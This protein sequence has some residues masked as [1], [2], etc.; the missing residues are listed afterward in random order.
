M[1]DTFNIVKVRS[2]DDIG[3]DTIIKKCIDKPNLINYYYP[4]V[5]MN[6]ESMDKEEISKIFNDTILSIKRDKNLD[7]TIK[8]YNIITNIS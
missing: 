6:R 8:K 1:K 7:H 3:Y 4:H 5:F 2:R